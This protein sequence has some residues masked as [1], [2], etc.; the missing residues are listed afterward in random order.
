MYQRPW[1]LLLL[2]TFYLASV[3]SFTILPAHNPRITTTTAFRTTTTTTT[4]S[5]SQSRTA[6]QPLTVCYASADDSDD[7]EQE[8]KAALAAFK[9]YRAAYGDL[10]VP[11]KF[12]VPNIAPWPKPSWGLRLGKAVSEMRSTGKFLQGPNATERRRILEDMGFVWQ[13]RDSLNERVPLDQLYQALAAY[14]Q[15]VAGEKD[16]WSVPGNY[17]VPD[18]DPW[19]ESV[20]GLPLGSQLVNLKR[21]VAKNKNLRER[22]GKLGMDL[23]ADEET[24][25]KLSANDIRFSNVYK[26]LQTYKATYGDLLVPQPFKVPKSPDWPKET[27]DLRLGARV[28]AIRSQGTFVNSYPERRQMLDDLG[29]VWLTDKEGTR[30]RR[31]ARG[32]DEYDD[33]DD[34]DDDEDDEDDDEDGDSSDE[35]ADSDSLFDESFDF[36]QDFDFSPEGEKTA[37]TWG[38]VDGGKE[39]REAALA[40]EQAAKAENE[41]AE[42]MSLAD[43]LKEASDRALEVG[44][45]EGLTP[46]KR[47]IKGKQQ[48]DIP[49]FNDDFGDDFVFEDVVEALTI[50]K[51][52]HG[53]FSNLT[54]HGDFIVPARKEVTGFLGD[55]DD[56]DDIFG[57]FD[58]DASARAAAAIASLEEQG[59]LESSEDLIAAEIQRLQEEVGQPVA[60]MESKT[61]KPK[62]TSRSEWPEHLA[63]MSLGSIVIRIRDGSL[64][65]RHLPE[66]KSQL[67]ALDFDWGDVD[68]F[69]DVPFEKAMCAMYAYYLIRGDMFVYED[70]VMPDE[71]PWPQALAGYELGKAVKRIRELQNFL[72]AYHPEK[73][74]LL[75]MIDFIWFPT[76]ALPLDPNETELNSEM[77]LLSAMGHPD[78]A[79]MIDIPMGLPD[80]IVADGP[81]FETDDPKLWWRKWHNWDYVKDYWYQLGRRDNGYVLRRMGYSQMA[82]EHEAKYGPGLF[83]RINETLE[84]IEACLESKSIDEKREILQKLNFYRQEMLGCT[85][86]HPQRRDELLADFDRHML[87]IMKESNIELAVEEDESEDDVTIN[88]ASDDFEFEDDESYEDDEDIEVEDFDIDIEDALG[89]DVD[90]P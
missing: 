55:D 16:N 50:Y 68:H 87:A 13:V 42:P 78:Y 10:K 39:L 30:R 19:P 8:W 54:E 75:R 61:S 85:D 63:G 20:R 33:D 82:D 49:W 74:S 62:E 59:D 73:V 57:S 24:P 7:D 36:G 43:S 80:K 47:V 90:M 15:I 3:T 70:F 84:E 32:E 66:R 11:S 4:T 29:F 86:I 5:P 12:V 6:S 1:A 17:V 81:F 51:S 28:N 37:P 18:L 77:L 27:W 58:I 72:E 64:E 46:N 34:D 79:K 60:A 71:D 76:M 21:R 41:Y 22:F 40:A 2:A 26:A 35:E 23:F 53:D 69:I 65:V 38:L 44:V 67:D 45:I 83:Q 89:L 52:I 9:L 56:D 31:T 48:K 14:K 25:E 88:G